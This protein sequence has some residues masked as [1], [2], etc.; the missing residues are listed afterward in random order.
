MVSRLWTASDA[1]KLLGELQKADA[2]RQPSK[3]E[4]L[5]HLLLN[6]LNEHPRLDHDHIPQD[7][8]HGA[9]AASF[10][11]F[12]L[13]KNSEASA[14]GCPD[15][16]G[17]LRHVHHFCPGEFDLKACHVFLQKLLYPKVLSALEVL[18]ELVGL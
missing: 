17:V 15:S 7:T 3:R 5:A 2:R 13:Q 6:C 4:L 12:R 18:E 1:C 9:C 16:L 10:R 8:R 14:E 11:G